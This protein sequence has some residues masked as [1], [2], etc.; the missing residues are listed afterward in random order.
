MIAV[1]SLA[2]LAGL[3]AFGGF[4]GGAPRIRA[5]LRVTLGGALAMGVTALIGRLVGMSVG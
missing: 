4:L 1:L 2:S 3:G 5:M